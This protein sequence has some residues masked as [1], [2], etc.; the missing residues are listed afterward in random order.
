[1]TGMV[2]SRPRLPDDD[3]RE[4]AI[5][6][7][8][9]N[10]VVDAG[11]GTGKTSLIIDRVI[12]MVAPSA[13]VVRPLPLDRL[14]VLTVTRRAAGELR[15][16]LR[17]KLLDRLRTPSGANERTAHLA[18]ALAGVDT[19]YVGTIHSF[20]DR[21]LR[22]RPVEAGISPRYEIC[23]NRE[24]LVR[25]AFDRLVHA[26][27]AGA[28]GAQL[29]DRVA[30]VSVPI[31]EI[32]ETIRALQAANI[33]MASRE[34]PFGTMPGLDAVIASMLDS[35]DVRYVPAIGDP[36]IA[37]LDH[38]ARRIVA[39]LRTHAGG[40][41]GERLLLRVAALLEELTA[42]ADLPTIFRL[43]HAAF[44]VRERYRKGEDFDDDETAW[45]QFKG[46][47]E[48]S[49][50][51]AAVIEP[52][53]AWMGTRLVRARE[54]VEQLYAQVK[55]EHGVLD[56]LDLLGCLRDLLAK[57]PAVRGHFQGLFDHIFIDEF[58]DTDPLQC[59]IVFFLAEDGPRADDWRRVR[60][61]PGKLTIVGDPE[62]SIF[63][64]RRADIRRYAEAHRLL[65]GQ[66]ALSVPISTNFRSRPGLV[67][68]CNRQFARVF[69]E[70]PPGATQRFDPDSGTVLY[71][72]IVAD[73]AI[74]PGAATVHLVP[75]AGHR[76]APL[77][78]TD[79]GRDVEAQALAR[80]V[81]WL[82]GRSP[83]RV[84]D[85]DTRAERRVC[86]G[87]IAILAHATPNLGAVL[88]AFEQLGIQYTAHGGVLFLTNPL[89]R[90]YLLALRAIADRD[91]GVAEAALM[92]PPFFN[93]DLV[94]IVSPHLGDA[95]P[96]AIVASRQ[97]LEAA[98][99]LVRELRRRRLGRPPIDTARD[100][101]ER[102]ALG[103]AVAVGPNGPQA[104]RTLYEVVFQVGR[105]AAEK[106]LDYDGVTRE[107]R[108]WVEGPIPLDPPD[109]SGPDTVRVMTIHQAKGLEFPVVVIWDG[110]AEVSGRVDGTWVLSRTGDAV[111]VSVDGLRAELPPGRHLLQLDRALATAER[112]RLFFVAMTRAR[113]LLVVPRPESGHPGGH[114]LRHIMA[115]VDAAVVHELE[116]FRPDA[117]P[118]W[119]REGEEGVEQ[120]V[121]DAAADADIE[122]ARAAFAEAA[123]EATTPRAVPAAVTE[124]AKRT[125]SAHEKMDPAAPIDL[126][127]GPE[128]DP[129]AEAERELRAKAEASRYGPT[130]GSTVHR[131]IQLALG[132]TK[133]T[134]AALV[135]LA[136]REQGLTEHLEEAQAD[137]ERAL[138]GV[139]SLTGGTWPSAMPATAPPFAHVEYPLC[140]A[141]AGGTLLLGC[142]DLLLV[143]NGEVIV[144]DFKTDAPPAPRGSIEAYP[145][146]HRQLALYAEALT[147][148]AL[149]QG[150]TLRLGVF[151]TASG[152][153][154]WVR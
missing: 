70:K 113:D 69:G 131:A 136:A 115:E 108:A 10:V 72:P 89:V 48:P 56:Q 99:T 134:G 106:G 129:P 13:P 7:R 90:R 46:L 98:R 141:A 142:V 117:M 85:P 75:Y 110:F 59:E 43:A 152:E 55:E 104:L 22:L 39:E 29:G 105:L 144:I 12:E 47:T 61:R 118:D 6:E 133:T 66:D 149:V 8:A 132:G 151:F 95:P 31:D 111:A 53:Y 74:P 128:D 54:A 71:E 124:E 138:E 58:Q 67:A 109:A 91:D 32:E 62:Q 38:V 64:F 37:T 127:T 30:D 3:A 122:N 49:E 44:W 120:I 17:Q 96:P 28:L 2:P 125:A 36:D 51:R 135:A 140:T 19:A 114:M 88:R 81:R 123:T 52:L 150:R 78:A 76:G 79:G 24:P 73:P 26:A 107:M 101:I 21:L 103:R 16:R 4:R 14:A 153:I 130:F 100:V 97:R 50:W 25:D 121:A 154:A 42:A 112:H 65:L 148:T 126:E 119:A 27:D 41:R 57:Q 82:V 83:V 143:R 145:V 87:D 147:A 93:L 68:F 18:Q 40:T 139:R 9:R 5:H 116:P 94:D 84:R 23:E 45:K 137:V 34:M 11:P 15:Y 60:L 102:T 80:Y 92:R 20:A 33:R 1:M 77:K 146:Y 35:R 86:H 63:R